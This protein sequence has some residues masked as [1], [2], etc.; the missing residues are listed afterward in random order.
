MR[1][2]STGTLMEIGSSLDDELAQRLMGAGEKITLTKGQKVY[3]QDDPAPHVFFL[4]T[5]Q[6][7]SVLRNSDGGECLLRI[8]LPHSLMGLTALSTAAIRDADAIIIVDADVVKIDVDH[9]RQLMIA[10]PAFSLHVVELLTNRMSDFHYRVGEFL[11][12]NVEQRLA[13]TL[14]SISRVD[15]EATAQTDRT[16]IR[17][18]HEELANLLGARR[19]T[20]SAILSRFAADGLIAKKGRAIDVV[21]PD[22]LSHFLPGNSS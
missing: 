11:A 3:S 20:I 6:A 4:L 1:E 14:L 15:P 10:S 17:L 19:P 12:Q 18:T 2:Y 5:G 9:F 13:Q 8:H 22:R 21:D 16:L 7:K